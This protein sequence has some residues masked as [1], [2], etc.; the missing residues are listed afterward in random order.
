MI[1]KNTVGKT[2]SFEGF[3]G[4]DASS[5]FGK[6]TTYS[7]K[8]FRVLSD[9]SIEKREGYRHL[10]TLPDIARAVCVFEDNGEAVLLAVAGNC[11][12]RVRKADGALQT[13]P[14]FATTEGN[15]LFLQ[16]ENVLYILD[17]ETFYRYEGGVSVTQGE[18]YIP[19]I[20][21][22]WPVDAK[23]YQ[24][25]HEEPNLFCRKACFTYAPPSQITTGVTSLYFDRPVAAVD[26]IFL[27]ATDISNRAFTLSEDGMKISF[28]TTCYP[29]RNTLRVYVYL[30]D[31]GEFPSTTQAFS[32]EGLNASRLFLCGGKEASAVYASYP[33]DMDS[34]TRPPHV[35]DFPLYFPA[36]M[37]CSFGKGRRVTAIRRM[38]RKLLLFFDKEILISTDS[39]ESGEAMDF[40]SLSEGFG[41]AAPEGVHPLDEKNLLVV[42][43]SGV[44]KITVDVTL[45]E[46]CIVKRISDRIIGE[47]G[48]NFLTQAKLCSHRRRGEIWLLDP[49]GKGEVFVYCPDRDC[50]YVYDGIRGDFLVDLWGDV[51]FLEGQFVNLFDKSC[52][53]DKASY[54]ELEIEARFKSHYFDFGAPESDKRLSGALILTDLDG[55]ALEVRLSD[56]GYLAEFTLDGDANPN[57]PYLYERSLKSGRFRFASLELRATGAARQRIFSA[58]VFV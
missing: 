4:M 20:G 30:R 54:G 6:E 51:A 27:G 33:V 1:N 28:G 41:C 35:V 46:D 56:G 37:M 55:G 52:T 31:S 16:H 47:T 39:V 42:D 49:S 15:V 57:F 21:K 14:V 32:Y 17:G 10:A 12:C 26:R 36:S 5:P 3:S 25:A 48:E 8:N 24:A 13:A 50:W 22:D 43:R 11:L 29:N 7:L 23:I 44:Y 58:K 18:A 40:I 38:A 34:E 9:G 19:L 45:E 2:E 53:A